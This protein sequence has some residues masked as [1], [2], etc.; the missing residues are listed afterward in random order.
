ME[1]DD[2]TNS[3]TLNTNTMEQVWEHMKQIHDS[4]NI[5]DQEREQAWNK[6]DKL[7]GE[8]KAQFTEEQN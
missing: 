6:F 2:K 7:M 1:N 8:Y 4:P 3:Q 5:T